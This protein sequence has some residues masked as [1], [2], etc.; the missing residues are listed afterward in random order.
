AAKLG[1]DAQATNQDFLDT[2]N[3]ASA[4]RFNPDALQGG[5]E[6]SRPLM[7]NWIVNSRTGKKNPARPVKLGEG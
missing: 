5:Q 6:R 7:R 2:L 3:V 4:T 1:R